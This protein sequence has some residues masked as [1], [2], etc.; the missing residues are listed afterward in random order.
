LQ[1]MFNGKLFTLIFLTA[2]GFFQAA[3]NST[4]KQIETCECN[5]AAGKDSLRIAS[6]CRSMQGALLGT[7]FKS[8]EELKSII[9][10]E[11]FDE[12]SKP[13]SASHKNRMV[14]V[15]HCSGGHEVISILESGVSQGDIGNARTGD[16]SDRLYLL[17]NS[18][19]AIANRM[20]LGKV[21]LLARRR[22]DLFGEGDPAFYD[23][24]EMSTRNINTPDLAFI[25]TRDSSEKGYINSFNH[26]TAQAFIT[27]CF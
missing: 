11:Y 26:L 13:G 20:E 27:S 9:A 17:V 21:Y 19:Y 22:A 16:V 14:R 23:L 18:P 1:G 2:F 24:A 8:L 3:C 25:T 12:A 4:I 10:I 7:R 15:G 6:L 5:S